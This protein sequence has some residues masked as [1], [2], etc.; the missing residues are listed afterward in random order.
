[1]RTFGLGSVSIFK[2]INFPKFEIPKFWQFLRRG[3]LLVSWHPLPTHHARV[4]RH[5]LLEGV[6]NREALFPDPDDLQHAQVLELIQ[7]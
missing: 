4:S 7:N 6:M 5:E 2:Q 3:L 1:M